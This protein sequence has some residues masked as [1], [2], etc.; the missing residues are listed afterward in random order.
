MVNLKFLLAINKR[1]S[2][3]DSLYTGCTIGSYYSLT[4]DDYIISAKAKTDC[5]VL[6]LNA[7]HLEELREQYEQLNEDMNH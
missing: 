6:R 7:S 1:E 3:L 5:T 4:K 2:T